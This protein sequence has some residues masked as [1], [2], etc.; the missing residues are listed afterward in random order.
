[1]CVCVCVCVCAWEF[2]EAQCHGFRN[3]HLR[4]VPAGARITSLGTASGCTAAMRAKVLRSV[5]Q[6]VCEQ[7]C[8]TFSPKMGAGGCPETLKSAPGCPRVA[9]DRIFIDFR[10]HFGSLGGAWGGW[11]RPRGPVGVPGVAQGGI[12]DVPGG[13]QGRLWEA[14]GP[15]KASKTG[16]C[17]TQSRLTKTRPK[18]CHENDA[19]KY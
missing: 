18:I 15:K 10:P 4:W 5:V 13:V 19:K 3:F 6:S 17:W 11:G 2:C 8:I 12:M 14:L 16:P 1:M 7:F 9:S